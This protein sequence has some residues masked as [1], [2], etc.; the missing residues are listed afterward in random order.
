MGLALIG[1]A[2]IRVALIGERIHSRSSPCSPAK[3]TVIYPTDI[4]PI[5]RAAIVVTD[6]SDWTAQALL[7][8]LT[9][10]GIKADFL[11]FKDLMASINGR[12]SF[13]CAG[14]DLEE[15]DALLVRDLGR[16]GA[17]DVAFRFETLMSLQ[18]RGVNVINPPRPSPAPP[19]NSPPPWPFRGQEF[20]P[21]GQPSPPAWRR[22]RL[23]CM[24]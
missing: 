5:M 7:H 12:P 8:S 18:E 19:T 11:N 13:R 22:R 1:V 16:S 6:P 2:L 3:A 9:R 4:V 17:S 15:L 10:K 20:P 21:P 14:R 23:C 24:I